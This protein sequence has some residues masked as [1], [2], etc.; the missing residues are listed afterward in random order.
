MPDTAHRLNADGSV[1]DVKVNDLKG[2]DTL[3]VKPGEKIPADG[4]VVKG[5]TS[6]NESMLTGESKPVSKEKGAKVIG[7]SINGEGSI[8]IEVKHTGEETFLSGVIKTG[9]GSAG[10]QIA[11]AGHRQPRRL[12]ADH[13]CAVQRSADFVHLAGLH[14]QGAGLC[15]RAHGHSHG[16]YLAR[17]RLGWPYRW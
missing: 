3:L 6:V 14:R 8:T 15:D 7:G 5:E 2:G 13:R 4:I 10:K 9:S 11:Y 16:H 1:Q 12:L 17:T